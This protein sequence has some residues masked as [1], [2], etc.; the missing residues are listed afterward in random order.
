MNALKIL[1]GKFC[2]QNKTV[3]LTMDDTGQEFPLKGEGAA[4]MIEWLAVSESEGEF[5]ISESAW[6]KMARGSFR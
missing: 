5:K 2:I 6:D 3:T 1:T 4:R